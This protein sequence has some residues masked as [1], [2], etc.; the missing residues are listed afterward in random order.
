MIR[1]FAVTLLKKCASERKRETGK[2]S[3]VPDIFY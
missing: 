2:S 1:Q 3:L